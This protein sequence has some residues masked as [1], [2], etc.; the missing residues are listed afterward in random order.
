MNRDEQGVTRT[1]TFFCV[2]KERHTQY[3]GE[4][5]LSSKPKTITGFGER[6]D[7]WVIT[8][9]L[10]VIDKTISLRESLEGAKES[11]DPE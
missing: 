11:Q 3:G 8:T 5:I 4:K 2:D 9:E 6:I 7:G 10:P 1:H